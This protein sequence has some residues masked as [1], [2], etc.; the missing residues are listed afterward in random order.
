MTYNSFIQV[1]RNIVVFWPYESTG[2]VNCFATFKERAD[3][4]HSTFGKTYQDYLEGYFWSRRW[5]LDGAPKNQMERS[6][7]AILVEHKRGQPIDAVVGSMNQ[8]IFINSIQLLEQDGENLTEDGAA[9]LNQKILMAF[10][11]EIK[12]TYKYLVTPVAGSPYY[13]WLTPTHAAL[14]GADPEIATV[15]QAGEPMEKF[16]RN[17]DSM[18]VLQNFFGVEEI[19][20]SMIELV[21]KTCDPPDVTFDYSQ[22]ETPPALTYIVE[23]D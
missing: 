22:A 14:V 18:E 17:W 12:S 15:D 19:R 23:C 7:G 11:A 2:R 20:S 5:V 16:I 13:A 8:R 4:N 21:V 3:I 6:Y 9:I 1:L 10:L